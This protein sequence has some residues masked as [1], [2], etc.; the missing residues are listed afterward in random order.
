MKSAILNRLREID[1]TG[2]EVL[3]FWTDNEVQEAHIDMYR[4]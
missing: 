2:D 1:W 4:K 3:P